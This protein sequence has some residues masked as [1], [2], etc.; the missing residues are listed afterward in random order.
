MARQSYDYGETPEAVIRE[1]W[2]IQVDQPYDLD[3]CVP[4]LSLPG[5]TSIENLLTVLDALKTA[6]V[7]END[8]NSWYGDP[9][10]GGV[11]AALRVSILSALGIEEV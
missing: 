8:E 2:A 9:V 11:Y 3:D 1:R 10:Q 4:Y 7:H 5:E 6:T